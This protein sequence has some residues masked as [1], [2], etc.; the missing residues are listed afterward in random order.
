MNKTVKNILK[1]FT[2]TLFSNLISLL[3][4]VILLLFVP[5]LIGVRDYGYWQ[6]YLFFGT[7]LGILHFGWADGIYL[8]YG[9]IQYNKIDKKLF[10]SQFYMFVL[11]QLIVSM[12]VFTYSFYIKDV[13]EAYI[14]KMLAI[15]LV[16]L[17]VRSLILYILQD[18]ARIKDYSVITISDRVIYASSL[19]IFLMIGYR[20]FEVLIFSDLLGKII[21]LVYSLYLI[22]DIVIQPI[23]TFFF[24]FREMFENMSVGI[25]LL[26]ANFASLLILG[27]VRYGIQHFWGIEIFG[28]ISLT[29]SVSNLLMTFITAVGLVLFPFLRRMS[30]DRLN[31]IYLD[32]RHL[33]MVGMF[34]AL[35]IYYPINYLLPLWLPKYKDALIYIS[36]LFPMCIYDG[37][38]ELLINTFMKT[39][40]MERSLLLVNVASVLFSIVMTLGNIV[41]FKNLDI[42]MFSIIVI[43]F[44][45]STVAELILAKQLKIKVINEIIFETILVVAFIISSVSFQFPISFLIYMMLFM[46]YVL[47]KWKKIKSGINYLKNIRE[48]D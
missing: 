2:Y 34:I 21:S 12:G 3:I 24:S 13:G 41:L 6:L 1:N 8:R 31:N 43:L 48:I 23:S 29:L 25:K 40:R 14:A 9:G 33:L 26:F 15:G 35:F 38:F 19:I 11:L 44:F 37:K 32:I 7:Y 18:T 16:L 5:K 20:S 36:V 28:K 27:V 42:M 39:L 47:I 30:R 10:H 46:M 17:N 4:S 22:K 45:R